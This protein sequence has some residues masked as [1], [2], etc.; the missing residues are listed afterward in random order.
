MGAVV[1]GILNVTASLFG[2]APRLA[3]PATVAAVLLAS[4]AVSVVVLLPVAGLRRGEARW[5]WVG[6]VVAAAVLAPFAEEVSAVEGLTVVQLGVFVSACLI[7]ALLAGMLAGALHRQLGA[8]GQSALLLSAPWLAATGFLVVWTIRFDAATSPVAWLVVLTSLGA[9]TLAVIVRDRLPPV[10]SAAGLIA[11]IALLV[12]ALEGDSRASV[13]GARPGADGERCLVL[14][15]VDSLRVDALPAWNPD[16]SPKPNLSRLLERSIVFRN[17]RSPAPWTRPGFASMLTGVSPVVHRATSVAAKLPEGIET[18]A[19]VLREEGFRTAA[20][21]YNP[22]LDERAGFGRG[23]DEYHM[24]P[25]PAGG[26]SFG[27]RVLSALDPGAWSS[28]EAS[29]VALADRGVAWLDRHRGERFF[30]WLH[31]FDPHLPWDPPAQITPPAAPESRIEGVFNALVEVRTGRFVPTEPERWRLRELY[32]AEVRHVDEQAG[33]VLDVLD[34]DDR[35]VV[36][37]A[38]DHGEELFDHGGIEHGHTLYDELLRVPLAFRL[39]GRRT[40]ET[41]DAPVSSASLFATAIELMT[42]RDRA[43]PGVAPSLVPSWRDGEGAAAPMLATGL[44][45]YEDR[46]ALIDG[47]RK[48]VKVPVTGEEA[49]FDLGRDPGERSPAAPSD[50][51][52]RRL[53]SAMARERARR[54]RLI[55]GREPERRAPDADQARSLRALGYVE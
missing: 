28:L 47:D 52:R 48:Y 27:V 24:F 50:E 12:V 20:I 6:F 16:T 22:V 5:R 9:A 13:Q 30:L 29:T 8:G 11:G 18:L 41:I 37:F 26:A 33:R 42:G 32:D 17:A 53:A 1:A 7:S 55:G 34:R 23:F 51:M 39:P 38:S 54:E 2:A 19:E 31:F 40:G 43:R 3:D 44:L 14:L 25:G 45:Y 35:C 4:I 36:A 21:G 15:T 49:A 10:G 46:V